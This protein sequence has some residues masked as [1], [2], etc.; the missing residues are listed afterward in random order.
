MDEL[1]DVKYLC[2]RR[3]FL[4]RSSLGLGAAAL[5]SMLNPLPAW[6]SK[7]PEKDR[8]GV[9]GKLH[10]VPKV[11]RV[12]YLFQSGGPSQLDL[13]DYK[14]LLKT[15][16]GEEL[17]ESVRK[18]QRLTGMTA[19]Q[20]SLPLA[21]SQFAFNQ[22]GQSGAWMSDLLPYTAQVADELC[23]IRSMHTEA[24]N[25]DPAITFFQTGSQQTGRPSMGSWISYGLGTDNENLPS[26]T[27]L[28][29]RSNDYGQPLYS[30]LW[31]NGFSP[32]LHQGVQFRGTG[33]PVL[34]LR[35]PAGLPRELRR[36]MLDG[37][38]ALNER[39]AGEVGDP[40]IRTRI[41]QYEL[42]YRMQTSVPELTDFSDE[43][44][45]VLA[46]YGPDVQR[47]GSFAYNCLMARRLV[48]RGTTLPD[49]MRFSPPPAGAPD[50]D[51]F[52]PL[53]VF[54]VFGSDELSSEAPAIQQ[55]IP[56]AYVILNPEDAA[57][58]SV[59]AGAGV[60]DPAGSARFVVRIHQDVQPGYVYYGSGLPG[61]WIN[62]PATTVTLEHDPEYQPPPDLNVIA[63]G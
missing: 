21:G 47:K 13:F 8:N 50:W 63:R 32:S 58:L 60:R 11:R 36:G 44:E 40:E 12:I 5:A 14:P 27:V 45:H 35:D 3:H 1:D 57:A 37:I 28:L 16:N 42:A 62:P 9:L 23:F 25:H 7:N 17:P 38:A 54:E 19:H 52:R 31:G 46:M 30:R 6:A 18:G 29:S 33:D 34:Y 56:A 26:F 22:H 59:E 55:R 15:M 53:A 43:P 48:E 49:M 51:N 20:T 10:F 41:A 61:G 4:S 39:L 24:I 2:T